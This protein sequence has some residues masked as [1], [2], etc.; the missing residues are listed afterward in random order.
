MDKEERLSFHKFKMLERRDRQRS[1]QPD[2]D[3]RLWNL[4]KNSS[5][6]Y[7]KN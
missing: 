1:R 5:A 6:S 4:S 2:V 3:A 7:R